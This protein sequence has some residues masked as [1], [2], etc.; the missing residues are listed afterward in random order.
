M[1]EFLLGGGLTG[2]ELN[3]VDEQYVAGAVLVAELVH[4]LTGQGIDHLI[5]EILALDVND[6]HVAD[7]LLQLVG[8]GVQKVGLTQTAGAVDK[9]RV[10][11]LS[12]AVCHR[13]ARG[14]S[15]LV[16]GAYDEV[17]KGVL[18]VEGRERRA[19]PA[20][21]ECLILRD[22]RHGLFG[23]ILGYVTSGR[24]LHSLHDTRLVGRNDAAFGT[25]Q[26][27]G[28]VK[29]Q[30]LGKALLNIGFIL[31]GHNADLDLGFGLHGNGRALKIH[32]LQLTEP[33]IG[34][35]V[36]ELGAEGLPD[37]MPN[38]GNIVEVCHWYFLSFHDY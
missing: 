22:G 8:D 20:G 1:E 28:H 6:P 33:K 14:V 3:I 4:S 7:L 15:K 2:D 18:K 31:G 26:S 32:N 29:A 9:E 34:D 17:L 35:H 27:Q 23:G 38:L 24:I 30:H 16:G 13:K 11:G 10:V 19:D 37:Q 36:T 25:G 21:T 5:G 12:G